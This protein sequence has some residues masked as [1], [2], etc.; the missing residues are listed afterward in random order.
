M[1][2]RDRDQ[3][4]VS[5][6][7]YRT[8]EESIGFGFW[9]CDGAGKITN[10]SPSFLKLVGCTID[11]CAGSDWAK[12]LHP[13][14]AGKVMAMWK[15][16][17]E[18]RVPWEQE[19]RIPGAQ[20]DRYV[21]SRGVPMQDERAGTICWAGINLD[22]TSQKRKEIELLEREERFRMMISNSPDRVFHQ[23]RDLIY[24][25]ISNPPTGLTDEDVVGKTDFDFLDREEAERLRSAKEAVL[26]TG[27]G[28]RVE[29]RIDA[30][31]QKAV[32]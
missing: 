29:I 25:W 24:T 22:I 26:E 2:Q 1:E 7:E 23:D 13:D 21:L 28:R 11:S 16:C 12:F 6:V 5:D 32:L 31:G 15:R 20:G 9:K 8:I 17:I 18:K 4:V 14:D 10:L 30:G 3:R 27:V 19:L